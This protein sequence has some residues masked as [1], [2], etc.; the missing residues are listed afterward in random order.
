MVI[1]RELG[2]TVEEAFGIVAKLQLPGPVGITAMISGQ[3]PCKRRTEI[4]KSF[5]AALRLRKSAA[6]EFAEIATKFLQ[7]SAASPVHFM[8]CSS[9]LI[10][11]AK[12]FYQAVDAPTAELAE[13]IQEF[14][15]SLK[16][17][18]QKETF[19]LWNRIDQHRRRLALAERHWFEMIG[20]GL[21]HGIPHRFLHP[22]STFARTEQRV[23]MAALENPFLP[24]EYRYPSY[25][26]YKTDVAKGRPQSQL[27]FKFKFG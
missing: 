15:P 3:L 5:S 9:H 22:I 8:L 24:V 21:A 14:F 4:A 6:K 11:G 16:C 12:G 27:E 1:G 19:R 23:Q 26:L 10:F 18:M 25:M 7:S 2:L 13:W 17:K 20:L